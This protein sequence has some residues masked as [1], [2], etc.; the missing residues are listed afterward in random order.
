[1]SALTL[2]FLLQAL[3]SPLAPPA[4]PTHDATIACAIARLKPFASPYGIQQAWP[5]MH[6]WPR[7]LQQSLGTPLSDMGHVADGYQQLVHVDARAS[8]VYVV[9]QGG[10]MG[11]TKVYGPLPLPRCTTPPPTKP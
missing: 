5:K 9:E 10:F 8:A 4:A 11:T 7:E 3:D 1:M 6:D 2:V